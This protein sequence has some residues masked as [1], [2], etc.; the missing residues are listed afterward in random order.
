MATYAIGD[1]QGCYAELRALLDKCRFDPAQDRLWLAGDLVNRG[2]ASLQTLRFVRSLG[3][4]AVSVLGNHD[5]YLLKVASSGAS[6]R[7]RHDTLQ[8]VLEAPDRDELI[9][10][11]RQRP[12]MHVEGRHVLVHAGLLP[13]W[14]VDDARSLAAEVEAVLA[15]KRWKDFME[16]MWGNLPRA[17]DPSLRGWDRLR[18]VVNAMSR[19]RFCSPN[20]EM[21][22]DAKGPPENAPTGHIPWFA[23][24]RRNSA[25]HAVVC[26]HWSALGFKMTEN[27]IA[28][29]S[30]CVW[31]EKLT[32]VRLEDRQV[33]QVM[34]GAGN[35]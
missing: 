23:H 11:L 16:R 10:W 4:T 6:T 24:P 3:D 21:E 9:D 20:G 13:Q 2:P 32:A 19:M 25:D 22:F 8:R 12:L 33:V 14:T 34:A 5:L 1:I 30:G 18:V 28:L 29:D 35:G 31:G 15:G 17:W 27:L 26:G 7:K